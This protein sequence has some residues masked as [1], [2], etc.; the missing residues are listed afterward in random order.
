MKTV[1]Q[2]I[3]NRFP[4]AAQ[5]WG[6]FRWYSSPRGIAKTFADIKLAIKH[7]G[8]KVWYPF[9]G[10]Q[11]NSFYL[12]TPPHERFNAL[13][14]RCQ[15]KERHRLLYLYLVDTCG[16]LSRPMRILEIAPGRYSYYLFHNLA[17]GKSYFTLDY[18]SPLA[19]TRGDICA[20]PYANEAFDLIIC[21]HL[22]EHVPDDATAIREIGRILETGG[23]LLAQVPIEGE[24]TQEA[25]LITDPMQ[26]LRLFGQEDHVRSYGLDFADRLWGAG[27]DVEEVD[28][29]AKVPSGDMRRFGLRYGEF[30]YICRHSSESS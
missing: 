21:Y 6:K 3:K 25:P 1:R 29:A 9:C 18:E 26:R 8:N 13:C 12:H 16:V 19:G 23:Q 2:E 7:R 17:G 15:S 5:M 24:I 27:L 28:F 14:P 10:W 4:I 30:T 22:L 11:G 20:I